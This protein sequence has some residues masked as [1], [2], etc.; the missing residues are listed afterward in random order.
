MNSTVSDILYDNGSFLVNQFSFALFSVVYLASFQL[1]S[2]VFV[3]SCLLGR[4]FYLRFRSF[5]DSE[6]LLSNVR[7]GRCLRFCTYNITF[8]TPRETT[9]EL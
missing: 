1:F 9:M 4:S 2:S 8:V 3:L 5:T 6:L 7:K